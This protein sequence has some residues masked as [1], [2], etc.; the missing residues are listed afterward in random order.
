MFQN[1]YQYQGQTNFSM[2]I[3][4]FLQLLFQ[5]QNFFAI[6]LQEGIIIKHFIDFGSIL[7]SFGRIGK[8]EG[9]YGQQLKDLLCLTFPNRIKGAV[10]LIKRHI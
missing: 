4:Y 3:T 1:S 9:Y 8:L 5:I 10:S 6:S 2:F 7:H